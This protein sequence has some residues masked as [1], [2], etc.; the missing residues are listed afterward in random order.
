MLPNEQKKS[1]SKTKKVLLFV[2]VFGAVYVI[3]LG[4]VTLEKGFNKPQTEQVDWQEKA[5]QEWQKERKESVEFQQMINDELNRQWYEKLKK[6][7][8]DKLKELE[9]TGFLTPDRKMAIV[10]KA[11]GTV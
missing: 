3:G 6:D 1:M 5:K 7:S 9:Q 8:T 4:V 10:K 11:N 2:L